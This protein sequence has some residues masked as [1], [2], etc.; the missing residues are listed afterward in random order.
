M[1]DVLRSAPHPFARDENVEYTERGL[2]S[3]PTS[4]SSVDLIE[5]SGG[6]TVGFFSCCFLCMYVFVWFVGALCMCA[7]RFQ[8]HIYNTASRFVGLGVLKRV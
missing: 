1:I 7:R 6:A 8:K 2:G 3:S 4:T 5:T